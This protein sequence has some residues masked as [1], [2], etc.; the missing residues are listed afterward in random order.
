MTALSYRKLLPEGKAAVVAHRTI[1]V[2]ASKV[3]VPVLHFRT[4]KDLLKFQRNVAKVDV[5]FGSMAMGAGA[6]MQLTDYNQRLYGKPNPNTRVAMADIRKDIRHEK[7]VIRNLDKG[8]HK[9]AARAVRPLKR[10]L[11]RLL[12]KR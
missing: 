9:D 11:T 10:A 6:V 8:L 12:R 5:A 2:G 1:R 3:R 7:S 4:R